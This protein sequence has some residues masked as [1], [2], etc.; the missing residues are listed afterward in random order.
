MLL[1]WTVK[2]YSSCPSPPFTCLRDGPIL[3]RNK[4]EIIYESIFTYFLIYKDPF[5]CNG[6]DKRVVNN[7]SVNT[8]QD[9]TTEEAVFY[10]S[11]VKSRS[12]GWS[13]DMCFLWS[14][15]VPRLHKWQNSFGS[16]TSQ[17]S[18]GDSHGKFG[19]EE[20]YKKSACEDLTCDLE[21][22]C[23]L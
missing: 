17:F 11:A 19:V 22:L 4:Q 18:V 20:E 5:D 1:Q 15:S 13:R 16:G 12:G 2:W 6:F 10:M 3:L 9:K 14:V 8:V 7:S 23:V 21:T